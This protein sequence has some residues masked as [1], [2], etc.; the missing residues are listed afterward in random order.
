MPKKESSPK[1][2]AAKEAK[3]LLLQSPRGMHDTLPQVMPLWDKIREEAR[4]VADFYGFAK[5]ETPILEAEELFR[6]GTGE[7]TDVVEKEMYVL[8]T[9]GGDRLALR[10]EFTPSM[11]RSYLQH[12]M[13]RLP[14]PQRLWSFG[15][16]F[17]HDRPQAGRYRQFY[18]FNLEIIGGDSDAVYD[19]QVI[20]AFYKLIEELKVRPLVVQINSIGCRICRPNYRKKLVEYY[21]NQEICRDCERRLKINPIRLLDC[22]KEMCQPVKA[23]VPNI[24][25]SLCSPCRSHLKQVLEYLEEVKVPYVPNNLLARGLDYYSRTVFEIT[26]EEGNLALVGGGR[27]D[28]LAEVLGGRGTPAV[29]GSMGV[30]RIIEVLQASGSSPLRGSK[31]KVFLIHIGDAAKKR[32]LP[33]MEELRRNNIST[34]HALGKDSLS[35]QLEAA[36]KLG[37]PLALIL[38]QREVYEESIIIRDMEAGVQE[39]IPLKNVVEEIKKRLKQG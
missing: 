10:P 19:A 8:K 25:D 2:N 11:I 14:Q 28:Y 29:G 33:L 37:M 31:I 3:S 4:R 36:N 18:Q 16:I 38:G 30:E 5:I 39:S 9:K 24:F 12:G 15:P 13:H 34:S 6:R 32:S 1:K 22:K 27:Y 35:A 7:T 23:G 20:L 26:L 21:R 17:R